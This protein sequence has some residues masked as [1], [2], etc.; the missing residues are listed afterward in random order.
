M[1]EAHGVWSARYDHTQAD[2]VNRGRLV[3]FQDYVA[4]RRQPGAL[5]R[6]ISTDDAFR[7]DLDGAYAEAWALS[8]YLCETQPQNYASYLAAVAQQP[9]FGDYPAAARIAD[10]QRIFG[11]DMKVFEAKFLRFMQDVE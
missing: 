9:L 11:S 6:M 7:S 10:F 4:K 1:F 8:F 5:A 3:G 2:R